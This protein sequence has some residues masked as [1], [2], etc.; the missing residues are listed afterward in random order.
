MQYHCINAVMLHLVSQSVNGPSGRSR[1]AQRVHA[2]EAQILSAARELFVDRGYAR[3]TLADIAA[4]SDLAPRTLYVRF[5]TKAKLLNRL[6]D[7][8][9]VG[10]T[11]EAPL[12]ARAWV[13]VS[14]SAPTLRAR[15]SAFARGSAA[16]MDRVTPVIAVALEA[17][18]SEP[19][20]AAAAAAGRTNTLEAVREFWKRAARDGLLPDGADLTWIVQTSSVLVQTETYLLGQ[21]LHRWNARSYQRW[22]IKSFE[23]LANDN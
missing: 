15:I 11:A 10:D 3:T 17:E 22:L 12:A 6:I 1:R 23:H 9:I 7:V 20:I 8:E 19:E 13:Q 2:T 14:L 4:A 5:E 18:H 21:R 16:I